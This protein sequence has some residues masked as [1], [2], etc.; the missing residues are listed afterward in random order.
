MIY[1]SLLIPFSNSYSRKLERKS[2][3]FQRFSLFHGIRAVTFPPIFFPILDQ[4]PFFLS[5]GIDQPVPVPTSS[6]SIVVCLFFYL[7]GVYTHTAPRYPWR[8]REFMLWP[9]VRLPSFQPCFTYRPTPICS[10]DRGK[11]KGRLFLTDLAILFWRKRSNESGYI[12][13][14]ISEEKRKIAFPL[15]PIPRQRADSCR[16]A[17]PLALSFSLFAKEIAGLLS[18]IGL[19]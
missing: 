12:Y 7:D 17:A 13:R 10:G 16:H 3:T 14:Y 9:P 8:P 15:V 5:P 19:L 1:I 2:S 18:R 11:P 6:P 4:V